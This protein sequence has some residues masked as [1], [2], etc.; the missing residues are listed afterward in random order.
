MAKHFDENRAMDSYEHY[1]NAKFWKMLTY[2]EK[3]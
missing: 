1:K 3:K 2:L